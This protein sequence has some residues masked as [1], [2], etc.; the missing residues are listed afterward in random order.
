MH[1]ID[2]FTTQ[3]L[4]LIDKDELSIPNRTLV[5]QIEMELERN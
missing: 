4:V 1:E 5:L 2:C 3:T